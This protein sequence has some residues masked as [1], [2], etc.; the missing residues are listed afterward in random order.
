MAGRDPNQTKPNLSQN[1]KHQSH[2]PLYGVAATVRAQA[3]PL[4]TPWKRLRGV[5]WR[6]GATRHGLCREHCRSKLSRQQVRVLTSSLWAAPQRTHA[7]QRHGARAQ[8]GSDSVAPTAP[9]THVP[10]QLRRLPNASCESALRRPEEAS[11]ASVGG[12]GGRSRAALSEADVDCSAGSA[13]DGLAGVARRA[14]SMPGEGLGLDL[15]TMSQ[16]WWR[17]SGSGACAACRGLATFVLCSTVAAAAVACR[18]TV[19]L[20][21]VTSLPA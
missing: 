11:Q 6:Q 9:R 10:T 16:A 13:G 18:C 7:F 2:I 14:A 19:Q 5:R 20:W 21:F 1:L 12:A 15:W 8:R 4:V 17:R 3:L